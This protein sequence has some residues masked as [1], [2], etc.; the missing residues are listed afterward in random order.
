[1]RARKQTIIAEFFYT[2]LIMSIMFL[3]L[4]IARISVNCL[5]AFS[6][7]AHNIMLLLDN[8]HV[9]VEICTHSLEVYIFG[10]KHYNMFHASKEFVL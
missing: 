5:G 9:Y 3:S 7:V 4:S 6:C 10:E 8:Y 2:A 1:M